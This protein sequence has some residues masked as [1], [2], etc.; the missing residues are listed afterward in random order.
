ML[1]HCLRG[2]AVKVWVTKYALTDGVKVHE[3]RLTGNDCFAEW[4]YEGA[5][6]KWGQY[7]YGRV[8]VDVC[9]TRED[10]IARVK[11]MIASMLKALDRSTKRISAL[12]PSEM[13][14]SE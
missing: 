11:S 3:A 7:G 4:G 8:G 9:L 10:A 1:I 2:D 6:I 14:P 12:N 5:R 13:V